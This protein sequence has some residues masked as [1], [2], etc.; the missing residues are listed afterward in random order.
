MGQHLEALTQVKTGASE[1]ALHFVTSLPH[2]TPRSEGVQQS[3]ETP[4]PPPE[5]MPEP[6]HVAPT[7]LLLDAVATPLSQ[8]GTPLGK[9][10]KLYFEQGKWLLHGAEAIRV[11]GKS[12]VAGQ[13][14]NSGD[15]F[16]WDS[17][18]G[19]FA[20]RLILVELP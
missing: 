15:S 13:T 16:S 18:A 7:H 17:D 19:P 5:A 9:S 12:Y 1:Q 8:S 6:T 20:A 14:L 11:N 10:W 3:S 2:L 4:E